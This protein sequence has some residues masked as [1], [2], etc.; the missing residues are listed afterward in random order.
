MRSTAA[1]RRRAIE[2]EIEAGLGQLKRRLEREISRLARATTAA[3]GNN[4]NHSNGLT[5]AEFLGR[6]GGDA[7]SVV[8][9]RNDEIRRRRN[10]EDDED[11]E[12]TIKKR[13]DGSD[14]NHID[15]TN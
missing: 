9:E 15:Y 8:K 14:S 2:V 7:I 3:A 5:V 1:E 4:H 10:D 6:F 13:W 11:I 12:R